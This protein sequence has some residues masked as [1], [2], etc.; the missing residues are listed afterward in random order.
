M[1]AVVAIEGVTRRQADCLR[2][3]VNQVDAG[4]ASPSL[5][6]LRGALGVASLTRV[7][8]LLIGLEERGLIERAPKRAR[9]IVVTKLG[10]ERLSRSALQIGALPADLRASLESHC[11]RTG[12]NPA[13]VIRDALRLHLDSFDLVED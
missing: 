6:D 3:I 5:R 9:S 1:S 13:D 11:Q 10:R 8:A 12:D 2:A 4:G 7:R